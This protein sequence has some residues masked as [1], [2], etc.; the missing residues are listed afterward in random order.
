METVRILDDLSYF[1]ADVKIVP[2]QS[3]RSG[4]SLTRNQLQVKASICRSLES[5]TPN[6]PAHCL[7]RQRHTVLLGSVYQ[8]VTRAHQFELPITPTIPSTT[9]THPPHHHQPNTLNQHNPPT[10][11]GVSGDAAVP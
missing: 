10:L 6:L 4:L 3:V 5:A 8:Q 11:E 2:K 9:Q 1:T 7:H